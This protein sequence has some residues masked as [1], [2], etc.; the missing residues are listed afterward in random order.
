ME[1]HTKTGKTNKNLFMH[2]KNCA[3]NSVKESTVANVM[4]GYTSDPQHHIFKEQSENL[5]QWFSN[6]RNDQMKIVKKLD[7]LESRRWSAMVNYKC[8]HG[9]YIPAFEEA[10]SSTSSA[11]DHASSKGDSG[12]VERLPMLRRT[13][14]SLVNDNRITSHKNIGNVNI[15]NTRSSFYF[16]NVKHF[17]TILSASEHHGEE[18]VY[19]GA[20]SD[21]SLVI[22]SASPKRKLQTR[23][24]RRFKTDTKEDNRIVSYEA[25]T[26]HVKDKQSSQN[27]TQAKEVT[28]K[29]DHF[30]T[31]P[32]KNK[33]EMKTKLLSTEKSKPQAY[34]TEC[35]MPKSNTVTVSEY[36]TK[37]VQRTLLEETAAS[38]ASI[39]ESLQSELNSRLRQALGNEFDDSNEQFSA[40][41]IDE[42]TMK[43]ALESSRNDLHFGNMS[44]L[45]CSL[46]LESACR[47][48][49]H[50]AMK[51]RVS[52]HS[53]ETILC[54]D[55][56]ES[57][58]GPLWTQ[59]ITF[60]KNFMKEVMHHPCGDPS[61]FERIGLVTFGHETRV[62]VHLTRQYHEVLSKLDTLSPSGPTPMMPGLKLCAA[63][64]DGAGGTLQMNKMKICPR[65]ILITDGK[66]TPHMLR[67]GPDI[68][69]TEDLDEKVVMH[70]VQEMSKGC[71]LHID[72][73]PLGESKIDF[74]TKISLS[75][76]GKIYKCEDWKKL[77]RRTKYLDVASRNYQEFLRKGNVEL[78]RNI[79]RTI[80][81]IKGEDLDI[82]E[83]SMRRSKASAKESSEDEQ[84][85]E[86]RINMLEEQLLLIGT[87]VRRGPDWEWGDQ[88]SEGVGTIIGYDKNKWV[89]VVWDNYDSR[90]RNSNMYRYE[91]GGHF[92]VMPV[93]EPR[94]LSPGERIA[95]GCKVKRGKDW[96]YGDQ[97]GGLDNVGTVI[98]TGDRSEKVTVRWPNKKSHKYKFG[99]NGKYEI[100]L[101]DQ[102][103]SYTPRI[104]PEKKSDMLESY[105]PSIMPETK[106]DTH[107]S[108]TSIKTTE[109][110]TESV[111][112]KLFKETEHQRVKQKEKDIDVEEMNRRNIE[113]SKGYLVLPDSG[114]D[115]KESSS[116]KPENT[117]VK[118]DADVP[119]LKNKNIKKNKKR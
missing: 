40:L 110:E 98:K 49:Y 22:Q 38:T 37:G 60:A 47:A 91:I 81:N 4:P 117:K 46:D 10:F 77:G 101:C 68:T 32:H 67:E 79:I 18:E 80:W 44:S 24:L 106:S 20:A 50:E 92:D 75:T 2:I 34:E 89:I 109:K 69:F 11:L 96:N 42:E 105:T 73:V 57:M 23:Q 112:D 102:H 63:A 33:T 39:L 97:D 17:R 95:V 41:Q 19:T 85:S 16:S 107:E 87:R 8:K 35:D 45:L 76:N 48:E 26:E 88:D 65:I 94:I 83:E 90:G 13:H 7:I 31:E 82:V 70:T 84:L 6:L 61:V 12:F 25:Q 71:R 113:M 21:T 27:R 103:E 36:S 58:K 54:L 104:M 62:Q 52:G 114:S 43:A 1:K 93:E 72:C 86:E 66:T 59:A 53:V 111:V 55:T 15:L 78:V 118:M 108:F 64:F 51:H 74:L 115:D 5:E 116:V 100:Q 56:S 99:K 30:T 9:K 3:G 14:T 28:R 29:N 119:K